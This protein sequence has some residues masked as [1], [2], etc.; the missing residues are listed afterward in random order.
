[1]FINCRYVAYGLYQQ[2]INKYAMRLY[3]RNLKM[4]EGI[5]KKA[6]PVYQ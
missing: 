4:I 3:D 1:M 6:E 2:K 5:W